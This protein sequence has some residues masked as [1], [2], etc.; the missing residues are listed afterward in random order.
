VGKTRTDR[1]GNTREQQLSY[2][3]QRLKKTVAS[4][5]KQLAR[6]DLDRYTQVREM[7]EEHYQEDQVQE[8][9]DI[10]DKIKQE[11]ACKIEGCGGILEIFTYNK[12]DHTWY[13]RV[14]NRAPSCKN[15][16]KSQQYDP[17]AVKGILKDSK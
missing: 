5:R 15:R 6:L 8:G 11:W 3:N 7:I 2:E 1:R 16:T 4:L 14:C 13:Y 10:L 9:Q 12:I 17:K